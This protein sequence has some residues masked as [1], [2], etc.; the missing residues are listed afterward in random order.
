MRTQGVTRLIDWATP[1]VPFEG[2][3]H[4]FLTVVPGILAGIALTQAK[5]EM[6]EIGTLVRQSGLDWTLVRFLAPKDTPYTGKVKVGF[7]DVR[8][9]FSISREDI[10]AFMV[11]QVESSR[12]L[13]SM[14]IIG[15]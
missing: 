8:M 9:R 14:P 13:H 3:Q 1:S 10:A 15:S 7:G 2:D 4:S 5:R 11:D 6:V 12:Y